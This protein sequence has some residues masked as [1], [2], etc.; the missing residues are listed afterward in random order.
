[1]NDYKQEKLGI[2]DLHYHIQ[3]RT[4]GALPA[5]D[6]DMIDCDFNDNP[7]IYQELKHCQQ[8]VIYLSD[9][10]KHINI[11]KKLEVP[12]IITVY[13]FLTR[14]RSILQTIQAGDYDTP[15]DHIQYFC[16]PVNDFA[17]KWLKSN[18][19]MLTEWEYV[20]LLH[21]IK[22]TNPPQNIFFNHI[23]DSNCSTFEPEIIK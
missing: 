4:Y 14:K 7:C 3:R 5:T 18:G 20:C 9:M 17:R 23:E 12:L 15:V 11:A 19:Q 21:K 8:S 6:S 1:M 22:K 16:Y 2:R 13:Y 10:A